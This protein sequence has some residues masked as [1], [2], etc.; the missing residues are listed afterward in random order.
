MAL[1]WD[2]VFR[3]RFKEITEEERSFYGDQ[4]VRRMWTSGMITMVG[5]LFM[6]YRFLPDRSLA[7]V[8]IIA[9][10][11]LLV[12]T[13]L[14]MGLIDFSSLRRLYQIQGRRTAQAT[15]DLADELHR[16]R[17]KA[18]QKKRE[19]SDKPSGS[20]SNSNS[21]SDSDDRPAE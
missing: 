10:V 5:I 21:D 2:K 18:E 17:K 9:V 20:D 13:I 3:L 6:V 8:W 1:H 11:L 12:G 7:K 14:I 4:Y 16:L 15:R 19:R